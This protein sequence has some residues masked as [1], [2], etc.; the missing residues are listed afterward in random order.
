[1]S[2]VFRRTIALVLSPSHP[3]A[4][5]RARRGD[6]VVDVD[7]VDALDG[8]VEDLSRGDTACQTHDEHRL[9]IGVEEHRKM[10][11]E[12]LRRHVPGIRRVGFAAIEK[13][14]PGVA[15]HVLLQDGGESAD[16][17]AVVDELFAFLLG[18]LH[19]SRGER[20]PPAGEP[21][22]GLVGVLILAP[23]EHL[24]VPV[25][26]AGEEKSRGEDGDRGELL[27]L[28]F[29][30]RSGLSRRRAP[31]G[32]GAREETGGADRRVQE[33][34]GREGSPHAQR[35]DEP[36]TAEELSRRRADRVQSVESAH[37]RADRG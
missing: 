22:L 18:K 9:R 34:G 33:D 15:E 26:K 16:A 1:M 3:F 32:A 10:R 21:E 11:E 14:V 19:R 5:I 6:L 24:A 35:V 25:R 36:E 8:V 29:L 13:N 7:H 37:P 27:G 30:G 23:R 4:K 12:D 17:V 20:P 2:A 31:G 28:R